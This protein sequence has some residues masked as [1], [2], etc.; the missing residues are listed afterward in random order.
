MY[1]WILSLYI[2]IFSYQG[3]MGTF[4][5]TGRMVNFD[6][7]WIASCFLMNLGSQDLSNNT[8]T[9]CSVEP[10]NRSAMTHPSKTDWHKLYGVTHPV[11]QR[12][13][14]G[15]E[16]FSTWR[17]HLALACR[18]IICVWLRCE[19]ML[20]CTGSRVYFIMSDLL[21][22]LETTRPWSTRQ[23]R[24]STI[25]TT[26]SHTTASRFW[27]ETILTLLSYLAL[28]YRYIVFCMEETWE[29]VNVH[30]HYH[31]YDISIYT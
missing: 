30:W 27:V 5:C 19:S 8:A 22:V 9:H 12:A 24:I 14:S 25:G 18:Y 4:V 11:R 26:E 6:Y 23:K 15:Q 13:D 29:H 17:L 21:H 2:L 1:Q 7:D 10:P 28:P 3:D 31:V 20:I 16:R